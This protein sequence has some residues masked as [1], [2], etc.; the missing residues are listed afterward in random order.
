M[1][2]FYISFDE[3]VYALYQGIL[4]RDPDYFG[5]NNLLTSFKNKLT[6]KEAIKGLLNSD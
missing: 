1:E 3:L 6:L 5:Y 2:N 4:D